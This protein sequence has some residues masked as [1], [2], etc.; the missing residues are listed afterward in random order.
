[1]CAV[2]RGLFCLEPLEITDNDGKT[3]PRLV[4]ADRL[5]DERRKPNFI[6]DRTKKLINVRL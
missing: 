3:L 4:D 2:P 5:R 6:P 1:M